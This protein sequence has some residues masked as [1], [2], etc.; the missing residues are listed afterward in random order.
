MVM[1]LCFR[2]CASWMVLGFSD[3]VVH[4]DGVELSIR[5]APQLHCLACDFR[6]DPPALGVR[7]DSA[8]QKV[9]DE[10]KDQAEVTFREVPNHSPPF[11]QLPFLYDYRDYL[12]IP[13]LYRPWPG[14]ALVPVFFEPQVLTR[15]RADSRY[16]LHMGSSSSGLIH[17]PEDGQIGFG[18]NQNLELFMWAGDIRDLPV[19]EQYYLL[20]H[21]VPSS[22][23][24]GSDFYA[25]EIEIQYTELSGESRML[26][27]RAEFICEVRRVFSFIPTVLDVET[28]GLIAGLSPPIDQSRLAV[29]RAIHDLHKICV[30]TIDKRAFKRHVESHGTVVEKGLGSLKVFEEW[31]SVALGLPSASSIISPL[32]VLHDLRKLQGHLISNQSREKEISSARQRLSLESDT[33]LAEIY[34]RLVERLTKCYQ[35]L[36]DELGAWNP[37]RESS[38]VSAK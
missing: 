11:E 28:Q 38:T 21:N 15:Y 29:E 34:E 3:R 18:M 6:T 20:S 12:Y 23:D 2:N 9:R 33:T 35:C 10:G 31:A 37:E 8:A 32:F 24:I 26:R 7:I 4:H 13:G 25:S 19:S 30:E 27:A 1:S 17:L 22:H 36:T 16:R 5:N 14:A